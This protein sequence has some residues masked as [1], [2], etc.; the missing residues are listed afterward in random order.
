MRPKY[1]PD[2]IL[3]TAQIAIARAANTIATTRQQVDQSCDACER[4]RQLLRATVPYLPYQDED[5]SA[6]L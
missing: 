3:V 5:E 6:P 2:P 1:L 4:S